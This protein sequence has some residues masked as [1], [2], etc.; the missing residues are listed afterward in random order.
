MNKLKTLKAQSHHLEPA[1]QV[2]KAGITE[3]ILEEIK[4]QLKRKKL[5]KVKLVKTAEDSSNKSLARS[6]AQ[7]L[8]ATLVREVGHTIV[9]Y[10]ER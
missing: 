7:Q 1:V 9:L 2:G 4:V 10:K 3:S 8:D 5:I 6:L